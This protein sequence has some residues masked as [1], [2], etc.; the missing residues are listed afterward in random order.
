MD[1]RVKPG[2]DERKNG[3]KKKRKRNAGRRIV[4]PA[5]LLARPRIQQDAHVYRR[6]TAVLT[7]GTAHPKGPAPGHASGD[8]AERRSLDPPS[9]GDP[10]AVCAGVTRPHLSLVQRAPRGPVRSAGMLMPKAARE[11]FTTPP[12]GTAL[13]PLPRRVSGAGPLLSEIRNVTVLV[14]IVNGNATT[15]GKATTPPSL[16]CARNGERGTVGCAALSVAMEQAKL[17]STMLQV[18]LTLNLL[19]SAR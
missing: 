2:N 1:C 14:T 5:V 11:R 7:L 15:P 6:S 3:R 17:E 18:I 9:G 10:H 13:A 4:Q 16:R 19:T 8:L 12:A